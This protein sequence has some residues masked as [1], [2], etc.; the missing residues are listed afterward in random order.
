MRQSRTAPYI[1]YY[2]K[3]GVIGMARRVVNGREEY[4]KC[5]HVHKT[6]SAALSCA[7]SLV[8]RLDSLD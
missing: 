8:R 7:E 5:G 1:K 2:N 4:Q 3:R 6:R